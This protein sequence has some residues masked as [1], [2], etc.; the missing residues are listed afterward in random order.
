MALCA[1]YELGGNDWGS[2]GK[3]VGASLAM[4]GEKLGKVG[5]V[6]MFKI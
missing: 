2:L 5:F 6:I 4:T 3:Q 1:I